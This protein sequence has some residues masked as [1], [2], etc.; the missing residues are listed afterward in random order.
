MSNEHLSA[1]AALVVTFAL[2]A[3]YVRSIH[4]GHTRPH[5]FTWVIWGLGTLTVFVAQLAGGAGVGAWPIG[6]SGLI[7]SY[8]TLLAYRRRGDTAVTRVDW[9]FFLGA[10]S[11]LPL[12][13]LTRDPL[14]AVVTL[15]VV[16]L[17]GFGPTVRKA[18]WHPR[19]EHAGLFA[20]SALRNGLVMLALERYSL[21]TVLF[22]AAVGIACLLLVAMLLWR[23]ASLDAARQVGPTT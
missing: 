19:E 14:W 16:D 11:A 6:I 15:T 20:L 23:R 18:Y 1:A 9:A 13:M 12:W 17:L 3:P 4:R 21:T 5:V 8:V 7:T 22:P 10:L 2:F